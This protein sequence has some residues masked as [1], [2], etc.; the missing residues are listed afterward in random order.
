MLIALVCFCFSSLRPLHL[1]RPPTQPQASVNGCSSKPSNHL[2][3]ERKASSLVSRNIGSCPGIHWRTVTILSL[4]GRWTTRFWQVKGTASQSTFFTTPG[5]S[6]VIDW[7][8]DPDGIRSSDCITRRLHCRC[9]LAFPNLGSHHWD[10]LVVQV[11]HCLLF[12]S[13]RLS[14]FL[15]IFAVKGRRDPDT[16][17]CFS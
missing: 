6:K 10:V 17:K 4:K 5:I 13:R 9:A 7:R 14:A 16:I 15:A 1:S 3:P 12:P 11:S 2:S 8:E